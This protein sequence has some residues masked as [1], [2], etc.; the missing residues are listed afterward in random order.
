MS[1]ETIKE[2]RDWIKQRYD[3][4]TVPDEPVKG[5]YGIVWFLKAKSYSHEFAIKTIDPEYLI[6][7][8]RD[9]NVENLSREFALWMTIPRCYN[10][11][12]ALHMKFANYYSP[13]LDTQVTGLPVMHMPKSDG[14]LDKWI[15]R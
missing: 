4:C 6:K 13:S 3:D 9:T 5:T 14:S 10:V 8:D 12:S 1:A 15:S 11:V 2:L 7:P